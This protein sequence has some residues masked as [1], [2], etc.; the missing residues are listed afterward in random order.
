VKEEI[1]SQFPIHFLHH[2]WVCAQSLHC[3][4][5]RRT[6]L[7]E[8]YLL[9]FI[10][11]LLHLLEYF[12]SYSRVGVCD[13]LNG[14]ISVDCVLDMLAEEHLQSVVSVNEQ[15][16]VVQ[17]GE[18]VSTRLLAVLHQLLSQCKLEILRVLH[19]FNNLLVQEVFGVLT[20]NHTLHLIFHL[21][22]Y[23]LLF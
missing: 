5:V 7:L 9:L 3:Y 4:V 2:F 12:V 1:I 17:A 13:L 8:F 19:R 14:G 20:N 23:F 6:T 22:V 15:D 16:G 10:L 11:L 18:R 21:V